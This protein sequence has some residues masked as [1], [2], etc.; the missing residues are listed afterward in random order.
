MGLGLSS[1]NIVKDWGGQ[2]YDRPLLRLREHVTVLR[3][4]LAGERVDFEGKTHQVKRFKLW[5]GYGFKGMK[6]STDPHGKV[7]Y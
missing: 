4:A 1:P 7:D 6:R 3:K 2:P 5:L